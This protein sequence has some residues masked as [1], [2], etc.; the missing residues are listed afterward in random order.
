M[1]LE[2]QLVLWVPSQNNANLSP[3]CLQIRST[4]A[5]QLRALCTLTVVSVALF[6]RF[7]LAAV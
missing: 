5:V 6:D 4:I 2:Q 1:L 3:V 7:H